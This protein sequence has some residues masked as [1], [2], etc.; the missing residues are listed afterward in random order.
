MPGKIRDVSGWPE[1]LKAYLIHGPESS[2]NKLMGRLL[3]AAGCHGNYDGDS[4][5]WENCPPD[6]ETPI[7]WVRSYPLT[8]HHLWPS[9]RQQVATL[10][11]RGYNCHSLVMV[12]SWH[13]T[14]QS[15]IARGHVSTVQQAMTNMR[16]A[17]TLIMEG[18]QAALCPYE[19]VSYESI[20][21]RPLPALA[22]LF[23]RIGLPK[24]TELPEPIRD[25]NA[26]YF[27]D[28]SKP[29]VGIFARLFG[30]TG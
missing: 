27:K 1:M 21:Q 30:K 10:R 6:G 8:H 25:E 17:M 14:I 24:L 23:V 16:L 28:E 26:K 7:V 29:T 15:Q 19:V 4:D 20:I 5:A 2:G 12:R 13:S 9:I 3:M 18:L 22:E 11:G